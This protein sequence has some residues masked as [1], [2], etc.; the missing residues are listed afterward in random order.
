M[1]IT[2]EGIPKIDWSSDNEGLLTIS[3][4]ADILVAELR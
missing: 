2:C 3:K 4:I 1:A